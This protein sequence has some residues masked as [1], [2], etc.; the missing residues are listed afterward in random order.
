MI[1]PL[2]GCTLNR[3]SRNFDPNVRCAYHSDA[4]GD[5]IEDC[6]DLK[7]EME[8]MIE[9]RSIMVQNIDN[10]GSSSHAAMQTSG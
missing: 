6:G 5:N 4:Q 1:T 3:R 9:D 7:R 2:F 10:E 8:K